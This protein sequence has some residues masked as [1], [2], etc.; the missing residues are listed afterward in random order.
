MTPVGIRP[1]GPRARVSAPALSFAVLFAL[2]GG[3]LFAPVGIEGQSVPEA[4]APG[5]VGPPQPAPTSAAPAAMTRDA[6][7]NT[8][9]RAFR[10]DTPIQADGRLDEPFY[11]NTPAVSDFVQAVPIE[12][13]EPTERTEAWMAFDDTNVYVSARIWDSEGEDGWIANEMRRD[14]NQLRANDSFGVYLDTYHDGRNSL[15]FFVNPIGGFADLQITNEGNPNF[16]WNPVAEVRTGRFDGGWTVEMAIPFKSLRYRPGVEQ[17][18]GIQMRRSVLRDNEW[19]YLTPLPLQVVG[20][21]SNG[22]F[23]VSMYGDLVGIE[24]PPVGRNI[25]VKPYLTSGLSTDLVADPAIENDFAADVGLDV[26]YA[27][28]QN[29]TLDLTVNTDFAQVEVDEQQVNLTRFNLFFPEKREFFLEG[30]GIFDFGVGGTG[31]GGPGGGGGGSAPT[32]FYSRRIGIQGGDPVRVL[33]GGRLTGKIGSFDV[34][35]LSIQ[36]A[37]EAEIGAVS[38]NFSVLRLRRD[39]FSRSNIGV[40]LENRSRSLAAPGESNQAWGVDG[41]FGFN[42]EA[43]F[44]THYARSRTPGLEGNDQSYRGRFNYDTDLFGG[45]LDYLVVGDDFNPELGFVR[46]RGF[47]QT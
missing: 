34:G 26:K 45:S 10:V 23:R 39:I 28:T 40:L 29:L 25:E 3:A 31:P 7:G 24:A 30:R 2:A 16:D 13:G 32:L 18:W 9:V 46:R 20:P 19:I 37:D 17:V 8:T 21:G 43:N 35:V 4:D 1:R 14:S 38:T 6:A 41:S 33:G 12:G 27:V 36:T 22:V 15:A 5:T 42:D 11:A 44:V 47:R